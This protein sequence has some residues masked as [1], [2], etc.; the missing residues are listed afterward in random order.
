[1][2]EEILRTYELTKDFGGVK[3]VNNMNF[4]LGD[5]EIKCIIGPNGAGK[6]TFFDLIAGFIKPTK[7]RILFGGKDITG[8]S[9]H[10]I[11]RMGIGRKFQIPSI[12]TDMTTRENLVIP[13]QLAIYGKASLF[14]KIS[15]LVNN[16]VD[17]ILELVGLKAR[18]DEKAS[19][20]AHG[21]KQWLELG[22]ALAND[23][24]LLLLDEPT[25]GMSIEETRKTAELIRTIAE[26]RS[27]VV[28]EHDIQFVKQ[29]GT[30]ITVMHN[31]AILA[32]GKLK[33]IRSDRRVVEVYL[34]TAR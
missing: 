26:G 4:T 8:S 17:D 7:G 30:K 33:D 3:A 22:L 24:K 23:P 11:A 13:V 12:Y 34:G 18:E 16:R 14:S 10:D 21:E 27:V 6:T 9:P 2:T 19:A 5:E 1:M 28:I 15:E 25:A 20:L 31:G 32:E 29:L